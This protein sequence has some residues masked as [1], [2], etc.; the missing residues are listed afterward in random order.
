MQSLT[1]DPIV[2][3][4]ILA[5]AGGVLAA[6]LLLRPKF[7]SLT[8]RRRWILVS[9]RGFA[10]FMAMLLMLRPGCI[11][12]VEQEQKAILSLMVDA[13]GSMDLPHDSGETTR[14]QKLE[15]VLADN[16]D[17]LA[18][19]EE[20]N[21][22]VRVSSFDNQLTELTF[23]K[24]IV[25]LPEKPG[26]VES[27]YGSNIDR[28]TRQTRNQR[29][30]AMVVFGDGRQNVLD[31]RVELTQ[32]AKLLDQLQIPLYTVPF[33]RPADSGQFAD[34]AVTNM[35]DNYTGFVKN[36]QTFVATVAARGFANQTIPVQLVVTDPDNQ[37]TVVD[38]KS[39]QFRGQNEQKS[40]T[41][42]FVPEKPGQ[43][44][45]VVRAEPQ[46]T[47][48]SSRNNELPAFLTVFDGGLKVLYVTGNAN[49]EQRF[50]R[51][52]LGASQEIQIEP[53]I[54]LPV[55]RNS[56]PRDLSKDFSDPSYDVIFLADID[57]RALYEKGVMEENLLAIRNAVSKG[58]GLIMTGGYHSFGP[59]LYGGT[60]LE[61]VLP[62]LME[63]S[64][65]Q[66]FDAPLRKD[67]HIE[68]PIQLRPIGQ[69]FLTTISA[70][71]GTDIWKKLPPLNGANR[72]L[73]PKESAERLMVSDSGEPMLLSTTVGGRVIAFAGDST[74]KWAM[75]GFAEEHKRFWRQ[76]ILWLAFRDSLTNTN[77]WV[78]LPQRRY[79][80]R[81][82][83]QFTVGAKNT[84]GFVIEDAT[85]EITMIQPDGKK[86]PL[87]GT[88]AE[89]G[90]Q[91]VQVPRDAVSESGLY[92]IEVTAKRNGNSIGASS[93]EF[94]VFDQD[95]EK[96]I[97]AADPD[98]LFRLASQTS[99]WGG[100]QVEP[101]EFGILLDKILADPPVMKVEIPQ[102]WRLG[103]TWIDGSFFLFL[104]LVA[105][106][107]EWGMRK[108]WGMV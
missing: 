90:T 82:L 7:T 12:T 16:Q 33:G 5:I 108:K 73:K 74:W 19:L 69:H 85:F 10:L 57:A 23:S 98:Q 87:S 44:R 77:V 61:D 100:Q 105:M 75:G 54:V 99:R 4:W 79:Q 31:P 8:K 68:R 81:S 11:T 84:A 104:F 92:R 3:Y 48:I 41:M 14:W 101:D 1:L 65:R 86:I 58:K 30:I 94:I 107:L 60:P 64:D 52:A 27:D 53:R 28:A 91:S 71:G 51:Q 49:H 80:P 42:G 38:F 78:N 24:G 26:G 46:A 2:N 88:A 63:E 47:E 17:R 34:I 37:E 6:L 67:L 36:R 76:I 102:K 25:Q 50:L 97:A 66:D 56:W 9:F 20:K 15:Q 43:Y 35:P 39:V 13:T 95:K 103:D 70:E 22:E 32:A 89:E 83:V 62:V 18:A 59:G 29:L 45:V 96:S 55:S 106:G 72:F 21:I 40:I 93:A